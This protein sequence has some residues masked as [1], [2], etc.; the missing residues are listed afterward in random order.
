[1]INDSNIEK[2]SSSYLKYLMQNVFAVRKHAHKC[3]VTF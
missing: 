2:L 3:C 1:M